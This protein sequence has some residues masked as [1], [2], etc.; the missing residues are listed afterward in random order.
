MAAPRKEA[1]M[2]AIRFEVHRDEETD[3]WCAIS[4]DDLGIVTEART[5]EALRERL[6]QLVPDMLEIEDGCPI[7]LSLC[8]NPDGV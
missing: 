1:A 7:E 4:I 8:P 3:V 5:L 2:A 6:K